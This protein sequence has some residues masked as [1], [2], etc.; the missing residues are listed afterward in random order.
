MLPRPTGSRGRSGGGRVALSVEERGPGPLRGE[1]GG[2]E[3][4]E[5]KGKKTRRRLF[6]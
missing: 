4:W 5:K 3:V 6:Y 1:K 2:R